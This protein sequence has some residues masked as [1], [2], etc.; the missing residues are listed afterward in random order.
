MA[1]NVTDTRVASDAA[2]RRLTGVCILIPI[3]EIFLW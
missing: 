3:E 1:T 2:G